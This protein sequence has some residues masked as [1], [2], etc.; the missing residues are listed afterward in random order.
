MCLSALP[1]FLWC[2]EIH[3]SRPY[4]RNFKGINSGKILS[5]YWNIGVGPLVLKYRNAEKESPASAWTQLNGAGRG[6]GKA[7]QGMIL[8]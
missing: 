4:C 3:P 8:R 6:G 2:K 7:R 5:K 1:Y